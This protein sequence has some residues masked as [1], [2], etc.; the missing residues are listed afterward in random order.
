MPPAEAA[1]EGFSIIGPGGFIQDPLS[2]I[3]FGMALMFGTAGLPHILMRFHGRHPPGQRGRR[4][5]MTIG[6]VGIWLFSQ[7]GGSQSAL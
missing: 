6:F 1:R 5:P 3:S 7:W 2:A 4:Q